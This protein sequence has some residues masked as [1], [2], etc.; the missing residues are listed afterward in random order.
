MDEREHRIRE[1][2]HRLW[3][4]EGRPSDQDKR[5]WEEARRIVDEQEGVTSRAPDSTSASEQ[6]E[7][8]AAEKPSDNAKRRTARKAPT[9]RAAK[10]PAT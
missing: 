4:G 9:K 5:H 10:P 6:P 2:A 1:I 8:A 3:E 7:A